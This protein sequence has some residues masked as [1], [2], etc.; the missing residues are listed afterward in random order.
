MVKW[1]NT[2]SCNLSS[3]RFE[4][5]LVLQDWKTMT[6]Q[7][8]EKILNDYSWKTTGGRVEYKG[9]EHLLNSDIPDWRTLV[10]DEPVLEVED[11]KTLIKP[12][13]GELHK[14]LVNAVR[15]AKR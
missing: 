4:S 9:F 6:K 13:Q 12:G 8:I 1:L 15:E 11:K 14:K 7:R 3:S 2:L 5:D 10:V